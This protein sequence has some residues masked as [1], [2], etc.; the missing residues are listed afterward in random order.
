MPHRSWSARDVNVPTSPL[1][2]SPLH[3]IAVPVT[4]LDPR[5]QGR[6][7]RGA[8]GT[9][10]TNRT[11]R[12]N[13]TG[14][15]ECGYLSKQDWWTT[16]VRFVLGLGTGASEFRLTTFSPYVSLLIS[17]NACRLLWWRSELEE[18][19][20]GT[21]RAALRCPCDS[22][23]VVFPIWANRVDDNHSVDGRELEWT[24]AVVV[25]RNRVDSRVRHDLCEI[26]W[27]LGVRELPASQGHQGLRGVPLC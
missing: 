25:A 21:V 20:P 27:R 14:C 13:S 8:R 12:T 15:G 16:S 6:C 26:A 5:G 11:K 19:I 1:S 3:A 22:T 4:S 24:I 7:A 2:K 18:E 10:K 17:S 23:T 9:S